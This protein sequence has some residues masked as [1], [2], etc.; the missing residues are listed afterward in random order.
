[1]EANWASIRNHP[2]IPS[3]KPRMV[4]NPAIEQKITFAEHLEY[5]FGNSENTLEKIRSHSQKNKRK[6]L[7]GDYKI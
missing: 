3:E 6:E 1:M 4:S 7:R 2:I 5:A